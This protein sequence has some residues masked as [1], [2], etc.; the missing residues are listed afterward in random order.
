MPRTWGWSLNFPDCKDAYDA[1]ALLIRFIPEMG[2]TEIVPKPQ[3]GTWWRT[4]GLQ[5]L[6]SEACDSPVCIYRGPKD[7]QAII[8]GIPPILGPGTRM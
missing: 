3:R 7:L 1:R 8:S 5:G 4:T 2:R 6:Q